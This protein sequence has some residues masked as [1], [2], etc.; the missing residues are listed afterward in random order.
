L[1]NFQKTT[2]LRSPNLC[3]RDP[4]MAFSI[5]GWDQISSLVFSIP[6]WDQISS[7]VS[8]WILSSFSSGILRG[9]CSQLVKQK[10]RQLNPSK[11]FISKSF[12][13]AFSKNKSRNNYLTFIVHLN[14]KFCNKLN[15]GIGKSSGL[16]VSATNQFSSFAKHDINLHIKKSQNKVTCI[17]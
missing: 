11:F 17:F 14:G 13:N 4:S 8:V 12:K 9:T 3:S 15:L 7:M 10:P 1:E 5:P 6:G 16:S 2:S